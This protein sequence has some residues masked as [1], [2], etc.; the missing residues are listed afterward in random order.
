MSLFHAYLS[1]T[2]TV[3]VLK[4]VAG[5]LVSLIGICIAL[6]LFI[7]CLI[8]NI[9]VR[10]SIYYFS[11]LSNAPLLCT[12]CPRFKGWAELHTPFTPHITMY[13]TWFKKCK[14]MILRKYYRRQKFRKVCITVSECGEGQVQFVP[15]LLAHLP[16]S[17]PLYIIL[18]VVN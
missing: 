6:C 9:F 10:L 4:A 14:D 7:V 15:A 11:Y 8:F 1:F 3:F 2:V 13:I 17:L 12:V 16:S 18:Q 5:K